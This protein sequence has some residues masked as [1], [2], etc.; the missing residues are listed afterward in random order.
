MLVNA[1][2]G[3]YAARGFSAAALHFMP[4]LEMSL[5]GRHENKPA[6][7]DSVNKRAN[8]CQINDPLTAHSILF[9]TSRR[10]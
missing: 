7:L 9:L 10:K 8:E 5:S 3:D 6:P 4:P 1:G 2:C